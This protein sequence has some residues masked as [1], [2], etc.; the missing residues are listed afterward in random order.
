MNQK[1]LVWAK[2]P[3]CCRRDECVGE[4]LCIKGR[5]GYSRDHMQWHRGTHSGRGGNASR[6]R[7]R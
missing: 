3:L 4:A 2:R 1:T 7:D 6:S 5:L